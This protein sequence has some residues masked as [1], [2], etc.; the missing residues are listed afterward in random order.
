MNEESEKPDGAPAS[1]GDETSAESAPGVESGGEDALTAALN[2]AAESRDRAL[3]A[4]A[5]LENFRRRADRERQETAKY[6]VSSFARDFLPVVDNLRRGLDSVSAEDR[7]ANRAL[8]TLAAGMEL[9]E[10]EM[11]AAL[12]RHGIT[13]IDPLGQPFD[14]NLHQAMFEVEDAAVPAG[15]VAQVMQSGYVLHDRLLRPALVAVAKDGGTRG[16]TPSESGDREGAGPSG[17]VGGGSRDG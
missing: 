5:E 14:H 10:R 9:T 2:E 15:C 11:L 3:R 16:A 7:E 1:P 17:A 4:L 6:A 12:E 8:D 13:R